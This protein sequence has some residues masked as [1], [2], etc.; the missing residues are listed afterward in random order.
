MKHAYK[1]RICRQSGRLSPAL[2]YDS[3]ALNA[4]NLS[5]RRIDSY[6]FGQLLTGTVLVT[7]TLTC[8]V[9]LTQSLR[10][11]EMIVN[12]GLSA[13]LFVYFTLLLLPT[14]LTIILPIALFAST[15]F[16]Y[17]RLI[18]DSELVIMR[19]GGCSRYD[20]ARPALILSALV[21]IAGYFLT[22]YLMPTTYREF[23]ELQH[24]IRNSIPAVLLQQGVF[25]K[26]ASGVTVYVRSRGSNGDLLGIL[27]HDSRNPKRPVTMMAEHGRIVSGA[28]GPRVEMVNGNRQQVDEK[29]GRLA[30]LYFERYSFDIQT[31]SGNQQRN[32]REPRERYLSEL[33]RLKPNEWLADKLYIEAHYRLAQP[34]L[35][36]AFVMVA[37]TLLLSG[38]LNRRGQTSRILAAVGIVVVIQLAQISFKNIGEKYTELAIV[39]YL[40]P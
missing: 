2:S 33:F 24:S 10:F 20:I 39:L 13:P 7:V 3:P 8:V 23:R 30:L 9:W 22:T 35:P 40:I 27:V 6:I 5:V 26:V 34:L 28:S 11:I 36:F 38:D 4:Y 31:V 17:N 29:D 15:L 19:A 25:N 18:S 21:V 16:V 1:R 12:R 14:F 32:W 37:L